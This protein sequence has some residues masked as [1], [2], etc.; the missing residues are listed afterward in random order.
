MAIYQQG[1][2]HTYTVI[3]YALKIRGLMVSISSHR[4]SVSSASLHYIPHYPTA[5]TLTM[6]VLVNQCSF[7]VQIVTTH[8]RTHIAFAMA[9][10]IQTVMRGNGAEANIG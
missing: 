6:H 4:S 5:S 10:S 2:M 7:S 1:G 3:L 8:T 9:I